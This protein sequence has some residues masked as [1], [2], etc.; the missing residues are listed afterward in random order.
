MSTSERFLKAC[1]R[2]QVDATPVW[3]MRQAGRYQPEYRRLRER[4]ALLDICR[5][6]ELCCEV[7]KLPV[8]QLGVDA[9][10]LFS[11]ISLPIGAMGR[12]FDIEEHV[13]PVMAEPVRTRR[14]I[15]QLQVFHPEESLPYVLETIRLLKRD[16]KVPLIGFAGAPFTL[17][18]YLIE[19]GPSRDYLMTKRMM[20]EAD[21]LW[22]ALMDKLAQVTVRYL[23]AQVEAG[24]DALQLFDSWAGSLSPDDYQEYVLPTMQRIFQDLQ[25]LGVPIIYFGVT[26]GDLLPLWRQTGA[27]VIGVDWRV[28]LATARARVGDGVAIQGN[29]DPALLFAPWPVIERRARAIIDAGLEH[30][31]FI[32]N[33]GHG[34]HRHTDGATLERL[35]QFVH[36]YSQER[37]GMKGT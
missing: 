22:T 9:A 1:R 3:F 12:D 33:L 30:S 23:R 24:A 34:V 26:T 29:L 4:Y 14:D 25:D 21:D 27:T 18:S 16:L 6:P 13:G 19:G 20:W 35:V 8:Q 5:Q 2:E 31:G 28:P 17:A 7:T 36:E 37:L 32:F 11:D 15:E 10:I